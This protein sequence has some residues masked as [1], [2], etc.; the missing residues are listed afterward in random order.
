MNIVI[1]KI[2]NEKIYDAVMQKSGKEWI[3]EEQW[4]FDEYIR[5]GSPSFFININKDMLSIHVN[6][7]KTDIVLSATDYL[8]NAYTS[9]GYRNICPTCNGILKPSIDHRDNCYICPN[10]KFVYTKDLLEKETEIY[11]KKNKTKKVKTTITIDELVKLIK[12]ENI[13]EDGLIRTFYTYAHLIQDREKMCGLNGPFKIKDIFKLFN[14][15]HF[16][17]EGIKWLKDHGYDEIDEEKEAKRRE[18]ENLKQ[19]I[20][21]LENEI[22]EG[23]E[24][25]DL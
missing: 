19:K 23:E 6:L 18:I 3:G 2:E 13:C 25:N 8:S 11:Y 1:L 10:C 17:R 24:K 22:N 5:F 9:E 4:T 15:H 20:K 7:T 16:Y 21:E 14:D 12:S